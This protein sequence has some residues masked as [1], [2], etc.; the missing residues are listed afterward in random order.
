MGQV[1]DSYGQQLAATLSLLSGLSEEQVEKGT[2][3]AGAH[4]AF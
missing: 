3:K 4:L 2:G 1:M